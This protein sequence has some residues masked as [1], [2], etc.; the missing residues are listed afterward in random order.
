MTNPHAPTSNSM[1]SSKHA[2]IEFVLSIGKRIL[3]VQPDLIILAWI[4][5][6][7]GLSVSNWYENNNFFW[8][9]GWDLM[10]CLLFIGI[11]LMLAGGNLFAQLDQHANNERSLYPGIDV[12]QSTRDLIP[13]L[14]PVMLI[15]G[16]VF[17]LPSGILAAS[18][19]TNPR[20]RNNGARLRAWRSRGTQ[21]AASVS[22]SRE[23]TSA[24]RQKR[25]V[26]GCRPR[27]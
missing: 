21:A 13:R 26:R 24:E 12:G 4:I 10:T 16:Y 7:A 22:R 3:V 8:I 14:A 15:S 9:R 1:S 27:S 25:R 2:L 19:Q 5:A 20:L 11:L 6:A 17:I 23:D 18:A